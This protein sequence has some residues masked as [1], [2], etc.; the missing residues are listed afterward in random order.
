M[1]AGI[2]VY[3]AET[4]QYWFK[5]VGHYIAFVTVGHD[6]WESHGHEILGVTLFFYN[7]VRG[8][9]LCIPIGLARCWSKASKPCADQTMQLLNGLGI[10][11][12]DIFKCVN[13]TSTPARATSKLIIG[14]KGTSALH[15]TD[16]VI[17]RAIGKVIRTVTVYNDKTKRKEKKVTD[18][19]PEC[20]KHF[21]E[22]RKVETPNT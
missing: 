13:D 18:S 9:A 19:F 14:E 1:Y 3:I 6:I 22:N 7:P 4:R 16:M 8:M 2:A 21:S 12:T 10:Q 5:V 15:E 20:E 11:K 17:K